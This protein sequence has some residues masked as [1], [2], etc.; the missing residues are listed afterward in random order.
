MMHY[1]VVGHF[2]TVDFA[3]LLVKKSLLPSFR[4]FQ[5]ADQATLDGAGYIYRYVLFQVVNVL[6]TQE[7]AKIKKKYISS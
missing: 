4:H 7:L 6:L 3:S 2:K 1:T 5:R